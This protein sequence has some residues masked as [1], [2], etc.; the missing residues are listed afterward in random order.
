MIRNAISIIL[1]FI[2]LTGCTLAPKYKRSESPVPPSWPKGPAYKEPEPGIPTA[3]KLNWEEFFTD[4][5]LKKIIGMALNNNRDLKLAAL[6][7]ERARASYGIQRAELLPTL[8]AVGSGSKERVPADLSETGKRMTRESYSVDFGILSWEID[9]FG[10]IRSLNDQAIEEYLA[11]EEARRSVEISLLSE[12]A[13]TYIALAAD[14]ETLKLSQSTLETQEAVY[15]LIKMR[16]E[17]GLAS[18]LDLRRAQTQVDTAR[19]EVARY[20]KLVAQGENA[21]NLLVGCQVPNEFLPTDL[22]RVSSLKEVSPGITSDVLLSRPDILAAEHQL[23]ALSANIGAA[24]AAFFPRI[25]LTTTLGTASSE[26]SRL[27]KSGSGAWSFVPQ[28]IMP[29]FDARTWLAL[30]A[31]KVEREIAIVQYE[32]AIQTAFR[33]VADVLAQRGTIR[34]QIAAQESLVQALSETYRLSYLR[35]T[36][37]IDNYLSVL[38]AQRSLYGA[39]QGLVALRLAEFTNRVILYKVMGGWEHN[40]SSSG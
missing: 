24:R 37:G 20:T 32:K 23:K 4:D 1:I 18:Q 40:K 5:Q 27:F 25:S 36:K 9:F 15:K 2:F 30:K 7:V 16:Y 11:T 14:K 21:L 10:R 12:V 39:Q 28:I 3:D 29:I 34:D 6:N 31:V 26:L 33:E 13:N 38:D 8:N 19:G 35:Y 17:I 22:G